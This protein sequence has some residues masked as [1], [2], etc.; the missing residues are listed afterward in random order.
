[1]KSP[2]LS[3]TVKLCQLDDASEDDDSVM[4]IFNVANGTLQKAELFAERV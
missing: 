1:M 2:K 4:H 3:K